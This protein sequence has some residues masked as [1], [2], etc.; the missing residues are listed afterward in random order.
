MIGL[1]FDPSRIAE[2]AWRRQEWA[3]FIELHVEQGAILE[4][5]SLP[6]GLVDVVSGSIRFGINLSGRATHTGSTPMNMRADALGAAAEIVLLVE[7]LVKEPRNN[8]ARGTVGVLTVAPGSI[9]TI[10]GEV[11]LTVDI[12]DIDSDRQR[13]IAAEVIGRAQAQSHARGVLM[14]VTELGNASPVALAGWIRQAI[15]EVS[16]NLGLKYRHMESG[17]SHDCQMINHVVPAGL[18][19]VPSRGGLS[20]VPE[21]WT[22]IGDLASGIDVLFGAIQRV[23]TIL[24]AQ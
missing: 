8:G 13:D 5:A 20:H 17:A 19:F 1:D 11:Y 15:A 23:D 21:E 24:T 16:S 22:E 12:R 10:P 6:I 3:A 7:A 2:T 14:R 9:T 4:A 18:L